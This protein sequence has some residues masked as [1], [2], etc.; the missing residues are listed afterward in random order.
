VDRT[1]TDRRGALRRRAA[2]RALAAGPRKADINRA[3]VTAS[4]GAFIGT[5]AGAG[6]LTLA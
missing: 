6:A 3:G 2:L 4:Q 1:K 5:N